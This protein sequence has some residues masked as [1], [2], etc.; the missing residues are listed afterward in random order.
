MGTALSQIV[1]NPTG[2]C[3]VLKMYPMDFEEFLWANVI[4]GK[5][6]SYL[7][8]CFTK[9]EVVDSSVHKKMMDFFALCHDWR[10]AEGSRNLYSDSLN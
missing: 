7:N 4:E 2:Y 5:V 3:D 8:E 6:I 10:N 9:E 1:L